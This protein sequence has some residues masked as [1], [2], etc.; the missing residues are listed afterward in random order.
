M[1]LLCV[2]TTTASYY[3][4]KHQ[5]KKTA[6][7]ELFNINKFTGAHKTLPFGTWVKVTNLSNNK[8]V[9]IKINDRGPF[10]KNREIDLSL[11]AFK[12]IANIKQGVINIKYKIIR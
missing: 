8:S 10:I 11:C 9:A 2:H 3:G 4:I 7:G 5:G 6:S 1:L 12:T